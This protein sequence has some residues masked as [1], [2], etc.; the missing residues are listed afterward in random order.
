MPN[1]VNPPIPVKKILVVGGGTAGWM[2][3]AYLAKWLE[4]V[5]IQVELV[6][7]D[8][9][10]TIGVGEATVPGIHQFIRDLAISES[11][12][13]RATNATFKL[14]IAFEHWAG[15]DKHFFHPFA[16]YGVAIEDRSFHKTWW[17]ARQQGYAQ[18]LDQ[19]C[20]CTQLARA[21]KF[22]QPSFDPES[23]LAWYNYAYHFDASLFAK[24]LR[25][26]AETRG[27]TRIEGKINHVQLDNTS[28]SIQS[29]T[30]ESGQMLDGDLFVDC[31]G[32]PALLI[33]K[34]LGV[35]YEDWS[36][37][38]PCDSAQAVQTQSLREPD[39]FTRS[40]A[41]TAGWQWHIPLQ[42]RVGNGYVYSSQFISHDEART[43]LL[44][45]LAGEPLTDPRL[46]RF[47]T[48]MRKDFWF[49]NCV[50]IGLSSGF[51]EPLESTSISLIQTGI[52]K[53]TSFLVN[54]E[55]DEK[56]VA[57]ANRLNRL[58]YERIRDFIIL[59][60]KLNGRSGTF[61]QQVRA[62]DV[63]ASLEQKMALFKRTGDISMLEQ[64]S[65]KEESWLSMYY[66]FG[67][68]P[69]GIN[70]SADPQRTQLIMDKMRNAIQKG[71]AL[72]PSHAEFIQTLSASHT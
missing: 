13:I 10:G 34:T 51:L 54:F 26:Y 23:R 35:G 8:Q 3:A 9:I 58:E 4:S 12:F 62:M 42:H 1:P 14:G 25:N 60:Y 44:G 59:H 50:A 33:G 55:I 72:A 39:P 69:A 7:S 68:D 70:P 28:G 11:E 19:F 43:E 6:E 29:L 38:L 66:G 31:T 30:L 64:E 40:S 17:A 24:F 32:I 53:M 37:W 36:H 47:T 18:E 20:L 61:W 41:R 27:V 21:G 67:V 71:V 48:G 46:I 2:T 45:N 49:K 16:G 56:Q 22:A 52:A 15:I 5:D 63:P 57:E 65:F